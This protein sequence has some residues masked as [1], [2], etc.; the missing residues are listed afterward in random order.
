VLPFASRWVLPELGLDPARLRGEAETLVAATPLNDRIVSGYVDHVAYWVAQ[1]MRLDGERAPR[2][3]LARVR[4]R[5]LAVDLAEFPRVAAGVR[6][7]A[8]MDDEPLWTA[9]ATRIAASVLP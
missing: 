7:G 1:R 9:L 5:G 2:V 6:A 8:A 3:A 4:L